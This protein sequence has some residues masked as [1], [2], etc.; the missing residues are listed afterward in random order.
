MNWTVSSVP[1]ETA[2]GVAS[3]GDEDKYVVTDLAGFAL[4]VVTLIK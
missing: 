2:E 4:R 1:P 3:A